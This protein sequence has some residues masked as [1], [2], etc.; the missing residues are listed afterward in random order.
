MTV[1]WYQRVVGAG[2]TGAGVGWV[3]GWGSLLKHWRNMLA[4]PQGRYSHL[5]DDLSCHGKV[6]HIFPYPGDPPTPFSTKGQSCGSSLMLAWVNYLTNSRIAGYLWRLRDFLFSGYGIF[7]HTRWQTTDRCSESVRDLNLMVDIFKYL[8]FLD[9][10]SCIKISN[11][12]VCPKGSTQSG[13][14]WVPVISVQF[15]LTMGQLWFRQGFGIEQAS[16]AWTNDY[17][18]HGRYVTRS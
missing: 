16:V 3:P 11:G 10:N 12:G 8:H 1:Q 9:E 5:H 7:D 6:F 15:E 18:V 14:L 2:M 17:L 4:K 13:L